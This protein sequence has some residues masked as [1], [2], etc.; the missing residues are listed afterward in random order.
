MWNEHPSMWNEHYLR[1]DFG[2]VADGRGTARKSVT[3]L[4]WSEAD[5]WLKLK[6]VVRVPVYGVIGRGLTGGMQ[7]PLPPSI[8]NE[9]KTGAPIL[10][11]ALCSWSPQHPLQKISVSRHQNVF[12]VTALDVRALDSYFLRTTSWP[13][14][15]AAL[16]DLT[17]NQVA[18][19]PQSILSFYNPFA[20]FANDGVFP[21]PTA[22][23]LAATHHAAEQLTNAALALYETPAPGYMTPKLAAAY[24]ECAAILERA[25]HSVEILIPPSIDDFENDTF[26]LP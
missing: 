1:T 19:L 9:F 23:S 24:L 16:E 2:T 4:G 6:R 7:Y 20:L 12:Y 26:E 21:L 18:S 13:Q 15:Q 11:R 17:K 22:D 8:L 14:V 10:S 25:A 5:K 3:F